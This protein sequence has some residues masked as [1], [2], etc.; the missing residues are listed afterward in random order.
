MRV[1]LFYFLERI[2]ELRQ[3]V[4]SKALF[5]S[6]S[7]QIEALEALDAAEKVYRSKLGAD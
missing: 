5:E 2:G 3:T 4:L 1:N 6:P 7:Q